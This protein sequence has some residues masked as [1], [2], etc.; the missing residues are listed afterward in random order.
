LVFTRLWKE[1]LQK[2]ERILRAEKMTFD[3]MHS[4]E[5]EQT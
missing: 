2:V 1:F 3:E 5:L 4:V